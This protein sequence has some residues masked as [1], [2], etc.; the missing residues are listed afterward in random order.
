MNI[1]FVC[2]SQNSGSDKVKR[3]I[4]IT[5]GAD[6]HRVLHTV[7]DLEHHL[8]GHFSSNSLVILHA[9]NRKQLKDY[10]DLQ[11]ILAD[12]KIIL[13]LPDRHPETLF[14]GH[15]LR[16]RFITYKDS[17]FLELTSVLDRIINA[18]N[19]DGERG[20]RKL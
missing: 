13:I 10:L 16:P 12:N 2:Q 15:R 9:N 7:Q 11:E 14:L 1:V 6:R 8:R 20:H 18:L 19:R 17:D 4:E 5:A 3:I